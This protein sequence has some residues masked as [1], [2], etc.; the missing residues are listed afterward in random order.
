MVMDTKEFCFLKTIELPL[1]VKTKCTQT[2]A[3]GKQMNN[4]MLSNLNLL[5]KIPLVTPSP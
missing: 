2:D 1:T 5:L 4:V 3:T